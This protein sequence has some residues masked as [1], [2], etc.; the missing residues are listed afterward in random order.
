[1]K[2]AILAFPIFFCDELTTRLRLSSIEASIGRML[3]AKE[4]TKPPLVASN[5]RTLWENLPAVPDSVAVWL[6][7]RAKDFVVP[8]YRNP[9]VPAPA[10][11][12]SDPS[13]TDDLH[14]IAADGWRELHD[15]ELPVPW[16]KGFGDR[17]NVLQF[18][19]VKSAQFS[20]NAASTVC[21]LMQPLAIC[22]DGKHAFCEGVMRN[23]GQPVTC[24]EFCNF[25][26]LACLSAHEDGD[27]HSCLDKN[28][29]VTAL[30]CHS[31]RI[32]LVCT[33]GPK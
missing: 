21:D 19:Y 7:H 31:L 25:R 3:D 32:S 10:F 24:D 28:V 2:F 30:S 6:V 33:C 17:L 9:E 12:F 8:M 29:A 22:N 11:R 18:D 13:D 15:G 5:N 1:M 14:A 4:R 27:D 23:V 16:P 20:V 26:G